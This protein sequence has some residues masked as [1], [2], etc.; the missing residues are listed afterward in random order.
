MVQ[1]PCTCHWGILWL[2]RS[3]A[4]PNWLRSCK[5][6]ERLPSVILLS[7]LHIKGEGGT[8]G[9]VMF[10]PPEAEAGIELETNLGY[11]QV[12]GQLGL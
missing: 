5:V 4:G 11:I 7:S 12:R 6:S 1:V 9:M 2:M 10:L 8:L 3:G